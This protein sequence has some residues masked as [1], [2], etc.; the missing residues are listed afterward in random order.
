MMKKLALAAAV[1]VFAALP[2]AAQVAVSQIAPGMQVYDS[3]NQLI[4]AVSKVDKGMAVVA[5][6]KHE[7]PV[8]PASFALERGKLYMSMNRT[9]LNAYYETNVMAADQ[10]LAIGKPVKGLEGTM[11]GTIKEISDAKVVV[12]LTSGQAIELPR[13]GIVGAAGGATVGISATDLA[14]QLGAAPAAAPA[15][16]ASPAPAPAV[17]TSEAAR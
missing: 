17:K 3:G 15:P 4:G 16:A 5:T 9:E 7:V 14:K 10:S 11:L 6:D 13:N 1:S 8:N 12:T 2:A